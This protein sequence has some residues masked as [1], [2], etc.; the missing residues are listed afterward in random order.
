MIKSLVINFCITLTLLAVNYAQAAPTIKL[1]QPRIMLSYLLSSVEQDVDLGPAPAPGSSRRIS[2]EE[3]NKIAPEIKFSKHAPTYWLV[4][5]EAQSLDCAKLAKLIEQELST[6]IEAGLK[7]S[8]LNCFKPLL[9]PAGEIQIA[10]QLAEGGARAGRKPVQMRF[11]VGNW[12]EIIITSSINIDGEVPAVV[13][14]QDLEP[15]TM[16]SAE[17]VSIE[18]RPVSKLPSDALRSLDELI[19]KKLTYRLRSGAVL[20]KAN[21]QDVPVVVRGEEVTMEVIAP[22]MRITARGTVRQDG[23]IGDTVM[24]LSQS[25]NRLVKGRV[26]GPHLVVVDM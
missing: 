18:P 19:G 22:H 2:R 25:S 14:K 4:E 7:A 6:Q 23:K 9:L 8:G 24:I 15:G 20:R 26:I 3:I 17:H 16:L 12:P 13:L 10:A 21:L 11:L 1:N 5:T